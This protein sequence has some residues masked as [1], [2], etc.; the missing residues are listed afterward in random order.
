MNMTGV[1]LPGGAS[2]AVSFGSPPF[3]PGFSPSQ[4]GA[5]DLILSQMK[6]FNPAKMMGG[7]I[8]GS[9]KIKL[10]GHDGIEL[11]G[12]MPMNLSMKMKM[13]FQG[14]TMFQLV[15]ISPKGESN[16]DEFFN[17][18]HFLKK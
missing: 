3:P 8:T 6:N 16:S 17:S 11:D 7:R 13:V 2:F 18:F 5:M 1:D 12:E 10:Q 4:P 9:K 14:T 15:A